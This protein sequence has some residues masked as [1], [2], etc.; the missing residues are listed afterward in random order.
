MGSNSVEEKSRHLLY[1]KCVKIFSGY[2]NKNLREDRFF[3][4]GHRR[5]NGV[6]YNTVSTIG[7][8]TYVQLTESQIQVGQRGNEMAERGE[9]GQE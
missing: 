5:P 1:L 4:I 9:A 7:L 8:K 2:G 3:W 6:L